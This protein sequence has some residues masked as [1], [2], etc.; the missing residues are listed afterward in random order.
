MRW[1][2]VQRIMKCPICQSDNRRDA[3]FCLMCGERLLAVCPG[4]DAP[5]P[6]GAQFC[7]QCGGEVGDFPRAFPPM[8][9]APEGEEDRD[10]HGETSG[11]AAGPRD[12]G[13]PG[14]SKDIE[15][16]GGQSAQPI[17]GIGIGLR[18][19][20]L[21]IY[22]EQWRPKTRFCLFLTIFY[23][24]AMSFLLQAYLYPANPLVRMANIFPIFWANFVFLAFIFL[25][26]AW[27][28]YGILDFCY[29]ALMRSRWFKPKLGEVLL[30]EGYV[31][32]QELE[33]ALSEQQMKIGEILLQK[34]CITQ[35]QLEETLAEQKR[36]SKRLGV[37]LRERG[38]VTERDLQ[39]ALEQSNRRLGQI[40]EEKGFLRE[41]ELHLGLGR[42]RFGLRTIRWG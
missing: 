32:E 25:L 11:P 26:I 36:A 24:I 33:E 22:R 9:H 42:Q 21:Y 12:A 34:G 23:V 1:W 6:A 16:G 40:L 13:V 28:V 14:A 20:P 7:D 29:T 27:C 3:K 4:C 38:Y 35:E 41:H 19:L 37:I 5:L 10:D 39:G 8:H 2:E 17:P 30:E 31:T 18:S 15:E